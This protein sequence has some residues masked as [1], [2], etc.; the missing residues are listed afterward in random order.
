MNRTKIEH[1]S[2]TCTY[3]VQYI[4]DEFL[5]SKINLKAGK[6]FSMFVL[7][8]VGTVQRFRQYNLPFPKQIYMSVFFIKNLE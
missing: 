2:M 1:Q 8:H 7:L 3:I 5:L 6:L 4:L